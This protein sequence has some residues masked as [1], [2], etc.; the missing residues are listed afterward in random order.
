MTRKKLIPK[1]PCPKDA[2]ID[3]E[4]GNLQQLIAT[5]KELGVV[6]TF[7]QHTHG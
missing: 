4:E 2:M 6:S 7:P 5:P 3:D 1:T